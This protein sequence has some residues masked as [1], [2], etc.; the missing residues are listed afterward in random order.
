MAHLVNNFNPENCG[1]ATTL[2]SFTAFQEINCFGFQMEH[3]FILWRKLPPPKAKSARD[4]SL[5]PTIWS[6]SG[7]KVVM[8]QVVQMWDCVLADVVGSGWQWDI[9][10][11]LRVT[12]RHPW[13]AQGHS[14]TPVVGTGRQ[15][16]TRGGLRVTDT[17][18]FTLYR[19]I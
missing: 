17:H 11:G 5:I 2:A 4:P 15:W 16:D 3:S 7:S 9:R 10:G 14:Q 19:K 6:F 12:V 18:H 1:L 8:D 13:W